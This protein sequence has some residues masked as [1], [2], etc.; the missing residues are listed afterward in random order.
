[1]HIN[2]FQVIYFSKKPGSMRINSIMCVSVIGLHDILRLCMPK[3]TAGRNCKFNFA[4]IGAL[5]AI[6]IELRIGKHQLIVG[7]VKLESA[8]STMKNG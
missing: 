6:C 5:I 3:A 1:M 7:K 2:P 4:L 8:K